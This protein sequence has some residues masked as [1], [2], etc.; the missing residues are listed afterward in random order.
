MI[1]RFLGSASLI[2]LP[3][4]HVASLGADACFFFLFYTLGIDI[5]MVQRQKGSSG[6]KQ[7]LS[8]GLDHSVLKPREDL[9]LLQ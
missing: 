2:F 9:R 8:A 7:E 3:A 1:P 5:Y 6:A 4:M